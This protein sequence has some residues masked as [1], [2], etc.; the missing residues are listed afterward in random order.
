MRQRDL[1]SR[2]GG[3]EFAV[4]LPRADID[5]AHIACERMRDAIAASPIV[6]GE[7]IIAF[8]ASVGVAEFQPGDDID[9]LL[10]RA[11]AALYEAKTGG[12]NQVRLA[13]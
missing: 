7:A 2:I 10:A 3:E 8:T 12:R 6:H 1:V 13:A 5:T 11:D 9:H 4:I